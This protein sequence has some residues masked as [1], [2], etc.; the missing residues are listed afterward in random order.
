[1]VR[2]SCETRSLVLLAAA[3]R[4]H[5]TSISTRTSTARGGHLGRNVGGRGEGDRRGAHQTA[6]QMERPDDKGPRPRQAA[7]PSPMSR[8]TSRTR[9]T[10]FAAKAPRRAR[11]TGLGV[12]RRLRARLGRSPARRGRRGADRNP[13][14]IRHFAKAAGRRASPIR[15]TPRRSPGSAKPFPRPRRTIPR[16]TRSTGWFRPGWP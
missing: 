5:S 4:A 13:K 16:A 8:S 1:M 3:G 11:W 12:V 6:D 10:C 9:R 14:R 15:S 7:S 2:S